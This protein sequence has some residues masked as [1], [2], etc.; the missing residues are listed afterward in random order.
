MHMVS[1]HLALTPPHDIDTVIRF[2]SI[3]DNFVICPI[4]GL[5]GTLVETK[6]RTFK[7]PQVLV[8]PKTSVPFRPTTVQMLNLARIETKW[9]TVHGNPFLVS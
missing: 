2:V 9:N 5:N 3:R 7:C 1:G 6:I 4:V 8:L